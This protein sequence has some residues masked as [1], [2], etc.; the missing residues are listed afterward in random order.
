MDPSRFDKFADEYYALHAQSIEI[1]G[2]SPDYFAQYKI[3]D[4]HRQVSATGPCED[5]R[6]LDFGSGVGN[7]VPFFRQYFPSCHLVCADVSIR[8]LD[9]ARR[10]FGGLASYVLVTGERLPFRS[11]AFDIAFSACVFHHIAT[12]EHITLLREIR[13]VLSKDSGRLFLYE[14]NP[15]NP[16]TLHAV[17]TCAFDSD[18]VLIPSWRMRR[19]LRDAGYSHIS[20][21]YRVFFPRYLKLMRF[22][23]LKLPFLPLGAQYCIVGT[24]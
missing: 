15:L 20:V 21:C 2:E 16:L 19:Q 24:A 10:R 1:T 9:L 4:V 7:S 22:L 23:E 18:A 17:N 5:L 3:R 14:H 13:R 8:S 12:T 6:I 11:G